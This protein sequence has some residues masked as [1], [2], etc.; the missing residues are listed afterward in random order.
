MLN[1]V[2]HQCRA[3]VRTLLL[4]AILVASAVAGVASAQEGGLYAAPP[5]P[6]AA[7]LRVLNASSA[8][9]ASI[10]VGDVAFS[11]APSAV[12]PYQ[13]LARGEYDV[14]GE[15][16]HLAVEAQKYYTIILGAGGA[17]TVLEDAPLANP[18]RAALYFYNATSKPLQLD[19]KMN[20]DQAAVFKAVAPGTVAFRE[21]PPFE[22]A[23]VVVGEAGTPVELP[24]AT[25]VS[26]QGF[27]VVAL[28]GAGGV[29]GFQAINEVAAN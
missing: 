1:P 8:A 12:S 13:Y 14:V 4:G 5:P 20:G 29:A 22:V 11:V 10:S 9:D 27:S 3:F 7:F 18:A 6:D 2:I 15:T 16:L 19:A 23:F 24:Q 21:V 25:M 26:Q 17:P 28:E